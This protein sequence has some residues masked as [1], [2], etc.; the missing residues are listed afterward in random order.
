MHRS[1]YFQSVYKYRSSATNGG[2]CAPHDAVFQGGFSLVEV[3]VT[4]AI[5]SIGLM[6]LA[7][8]QAQGMQ[9]NTSAYSRTQASILTGDIIDR[10]RLNSGDAASYDTASFSPN[11]SSC[12]VTGAPDADN[13]RHCW[14]GHIQETLPSGDGSISVNGSTGVV[15][16]NLSWQERPAGRR[17]DDFD[18]GSLTSAEL[19]ELRIQQM[20]MS[21]VL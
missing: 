14:Y 8:L 5:L 13:D 12:T 2:F 19:D 20:S 17:D 9:L 18:P 16:V 7:F 10:M 21:V 3:L 11:P 1:S 4:L 6:G 15:T